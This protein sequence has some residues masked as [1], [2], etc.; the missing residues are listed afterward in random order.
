[1]RGTTVSTLLLLLPLQCVSP[2]GAHA[3]INAWTRNGPASGSATAAGVFAIQTA[4]FVV[5]SSDDGADVKPG[6]GVCATEAGVCT[7]RAAIDEANALSGG[8]TI[9]F[10]LILPTTITLTTNT[11]L[12]ISGDVTISGP[13]TGVLAI[14]GNHETRVFDITTGAV[15][16]TNLIIQNGRVEASSGGGGIFVADGASLTLTNCTLTHN[17]A[18]RANEGGALYVTDGGTAKLTNC[19]VSENSAYYPGG[20][21]ANSGIVTLTNCTLS[22]NTGGY[23]GGGGLYNEG[24]ATLTNCTLSGNSAQMGDGIEGPATLTNTIV[25]N[26]ASENCQGTVVSLGHNLDSDG[27]CGLAA[28][29][30]LSHVDPRL[31]QLQDNGGPTFTHALLPGSPAIDAGSPDCPPPATDQR[32]AKRIPPCDIGA[33]ELVPINCVGDCNAG[34]SVT[35]DEIMTIVNIALG[36][37]GP[38]ACAN[39]VPTGAAINVA[40]IIQAVNNALTGCPAP[41]PRLA[42]SG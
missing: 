7:L 12:A 38:S 32:G 30:D 28:P 24:T 1:M 33:Y 5:D 10:N 40:L 34:A 6:D 19:T 26:N 25:A 31:G 39:G 35:V 36:P 21:V 20:G 9:A 23:G 3:G 4:T 11:E 27:T 2:S 42:G 15:R 8:S 22:G 41:G 14:D 18:A 13:T 29:G 17:A 37:A 16:M